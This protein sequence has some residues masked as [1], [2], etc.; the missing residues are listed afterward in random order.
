MILIFDFLIRKFTQRLV[1]LREM[2]LPISILSTF[3]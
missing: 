1:M 2:L 3:Y